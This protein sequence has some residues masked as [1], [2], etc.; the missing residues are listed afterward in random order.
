MALLG[1]FSPTQK[2]RMTP[3]LQETLPDIEEGASHPGGGHLGG[4]CRQHCMLWGKTGCFLPGI[5]LGVLASV[6]DRGKRENASL[7]ERKK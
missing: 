2:E 6:G 5:T 3:T 4:T 1:G 7:L